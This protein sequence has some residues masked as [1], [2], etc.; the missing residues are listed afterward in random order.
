M[1]YD[2]FI[3]Y[4][5]TP[6]DK[7]IA[8]MVHTG[9]ETYH[10]PGNVSLKTGKKK[11]NR[12]FRDEE[13]LP[14]GSD[15]NDNILKALE[16]SEFLIVI[17][18]PDTSGSIW[19]QREIETFIK[20]HGRQN[21]LAVLANGEPG[22]SFPKPLLEDENGDPVEPLAADVRGETK[23]DR[24]KKFKTEL[25]RL[26]APII[27]CTFDDLKQRHRERMIKRAVAFTAL[28]AVV[29]AAAG[30]A[31]GIYNSNVADKMEALADEKS[32]LADEKTKMADEILNEYMGKQKN[33]SRFLAREALSLLEAGNREDAALVA[34][35]ALPKKD[36]RPYTAEAEYALASA[37]HAYDSGARYGFDRLLELDTTPNKIFIDKDKKYLTV[38][39]NKNRVY[40]YETGNFKRIAKIYPEI[41]EDERELEVINAYCD[42]DGIYVINK[43]DLVIY[44]QS[45]KLLNK[46]NIGNSITYV[47]YCA[48]TETFYCVSGRSIFGVDKKTGKRQEYNDGTD[49]YF[50][51]D[52]EFFADGAYV[53]FAHY[54][55]DDEEGKNS[56]CILNTK[57][58]TIKKVIIDNNYVSRMHFTTDGKL[59]VLSTLSIEKSIGKTDP[60]YSI[61]I[62]DPV[63]GMITASVKIKASIYNPSSYR[64]CLD[65]FKDDGKTRIVFTADKSLWVVDEEDCGIILKVELPGS[66]RD[67]TRTG[68]KVYRAAYS[69]GDLDCV[70]LSEGKNDESKLI[71]TNVNIGQMLYLSDG[72]AIKNNSTPGI[73]I[74]TRHRASDLESLKQLEYNLV[75]VAASAD[76]GC[77]ATREFYESKIYHFFDGKGNELF[78]FDKA[79]DQ[80]KATGFYENK[81]IYAV[82]DGLYLI[83]P[84]A[85]Q[86]EFINI[87]DEK[88]VNFN[89]V[90]L[91]GKNRYAVCEYS[92]RLIVFDIKEKKLIYDSVQESNI[93]AAAVDSKGNYLYACIRKNGFLRVDIKSGKAEKI[94]DINSV[95]GMVLSF[96]DRYA[97]IRCNDGKIVVINLEDTKVEKEIGLF[98]LDKGYAGFTDDNDHLVVQG[99]DYKVSIISLKD[100]ETVSSFDT[101]QNLKIQ[102]VSEDEGKI[103]LNTG[104][105]IYLVDKG[106]YGLLG[107]IENALAYISA[108]RAI[109][110]TAGKTL[111]RT[112]YKDYKELLKEVKRQFPDSAL[113]KEKR[114]KYLMD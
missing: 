46:T 7:E 2:A 99:E 54:I 56:I 36:E 23:S 87:L 72:V 42:D 71:Q 95:F 51:G 64:T 48:E 109:L 40:C 76:G 114:V 111:Y 68:D 32:K 85:A 83:D 92:K 22:D 34:A 98:S 113:S 29:V 52:I 60:E 107:Y 45:G 81:F 15:L 33:Q 1:K 16:G 74:F 28:C 10:V 43:N 61:D 55:K 59:V 66:I 96:D 103:V 27:G 25:L 37:L 20:L 8:K 78:R 70:D 35:A 100:Y 67:I 11:I 62:V 112:F 108:D 53:A 44:D 9:L 41:D 38:I 82:H 101:K 73:Y 19:V 14:I 93:D 77:A 13:E 89:E 94:A 58:N 12:V 39:D 90:I 79:G 31:F 17:C 86:F 26:A 88:N 3:S 75:G 91:C 6:L 18:T 50:T 65:D 80:P 49:L 24:K 21:I 5:H 69:N 63:Q 97:A 110:L 57:D 104:Y 30:T 102:S 4:R 47:R 105:D 106:E 84:Y